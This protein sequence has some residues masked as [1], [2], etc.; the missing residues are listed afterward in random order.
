MIVSQVPISYPTQ[1]IE[2]F[3]ARYHQACLCFH[4]SMV[5]TMHTSPVYPSTCICKELFGLKH[6]SKGAAFAVLLGSTPRLFL[7]ESTSD[8]RDPGRR[9]GVGAGATGHPQPVHCDGRRGGELALI[10]WLLFTGVDS[11]RWYARALHPA[12]TEN[13]RFP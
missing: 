2:D 11:E 3:A 12:F 5:I 10:L 13:D 4:T 6:L 7:K 9:A 1:L 8:S